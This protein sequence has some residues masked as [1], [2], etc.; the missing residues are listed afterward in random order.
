MSGI[1]LLCSLIGGARVID[2]RGGAPIDNA[3][4]VIRDGRIVA[5]GPSA[6]TPV[7]VGRRSLT[8]LAKPY[9]DDV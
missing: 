8:M 7:P 1:S 5:V 9:V 4:I 6:G 2:G 3:P